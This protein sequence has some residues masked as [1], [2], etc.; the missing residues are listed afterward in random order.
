MAKCRNRG[1]VSEEASSLEGKRSREMR[2]LEA[3]DRT[4]EISQRDLARQLAL[5][6]AVTNRLVRS[7]VKE[8]YLRCT[9]KGWNRWTY[10]LTPAG[11]AR[12]L[13]LTVAYVE[14]FLDH[15]GRVRGLLV[16]DLGWPGLDPVP[17]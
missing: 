15:Y 9:Q 1:S 3:V 7:L 6:L 12:K 2:L 14:R 4:P 13:R 5:A 11:A 8:G 16:G 10:V 17:G